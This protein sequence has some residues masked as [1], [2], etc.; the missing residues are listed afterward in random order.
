MTFLFR[1]EAA[2]DVL[3]AWEWYEGQQKG[4]GAEFLNAVEEALSLVADFDESFPIVRADVRRALLRSFPYSLYYRQRDRSTIEVVACLHTRRSPTT[5]P[6][7]L[8]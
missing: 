4:L 3:S 8:S 7:R 1:T 2:A 5:L 6:N